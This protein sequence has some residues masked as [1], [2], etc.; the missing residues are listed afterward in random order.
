MTMRSLAQ[1]GVF[2]LLLA[3]LLGVLV[4]VGLFTFVYGEGH[5]YLSDD[6]TACINCHIMQDQH[7]SWLKSSHHAHATCNDCHLPH[8]A[9]RWIAKADNGFFHSW[10][11]TFQDFHEPIQIK[12]RNLQILQDNCVSCHQTMTHQM[13]PATVAGEATSCFH[14]HHSVGHGG[15]LAGSPRRFPMLI[16]ANP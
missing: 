3:T 11:F 12:Q 7:D 8:G 6:P 10:A 16:G 2:P 15:R 14:C 1:L 4:G 5:S 9:T 13:L